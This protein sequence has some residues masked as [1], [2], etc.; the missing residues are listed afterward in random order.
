MFAFIGMGGWA[1]FANHGHAMPAPLLA[2]LV[3]GGLSASITLFLKRLVEAL[4]ARFSGIAAL[5]APPAIACVVS[6]SLLTLIHT[7]AGTPE[8]LATIIVPLTVATS[9]AAVYNYSL[10]RLARG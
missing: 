10:W 5:L 3:Q 4:A 7:L 9:Y 8:V 2:G 6:A 1:A